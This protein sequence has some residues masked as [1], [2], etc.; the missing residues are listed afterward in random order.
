LTSPWTG[1][2][3]R[4]TFERGDARKGGSSEGIRSEKVRVFRFVRK[5]FKGDLLSTMPVAA[6][7]SKK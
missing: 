4:S 7:G 1:V 5:V 2:R 3:Y 6:R